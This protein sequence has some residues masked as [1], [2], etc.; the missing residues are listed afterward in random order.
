MY[1]GECKFGAS[2]KFHHP[3]YPAD[4]VFDNG[5]RMGSRSSV[6]QPASPAPA[7]SLLLPPGSAGKLRRPS[8]DV[9][10]LHPILDRR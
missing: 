8:S 4:H 7:A 6:S 1:A 2:C 10:K 5:L 3:N 9:S